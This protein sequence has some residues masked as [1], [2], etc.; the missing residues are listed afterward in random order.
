M[1]TSITS[2]RDRRFAAAVVEVA[3]E[4]EVIGARYDWHGTP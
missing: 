4:V 2:M 1:V 3:N